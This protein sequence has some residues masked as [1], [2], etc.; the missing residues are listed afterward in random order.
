L[1]PR[2][3]WKL[4]ISDLDGSLTETS[5]GMEFSFLLKERG[6]LKEKVWCQMVKF[7]EESRPHRNSILGYNFYIKHLSV[8]FAKGIYGAKVETVEEIA[9]ELAPKIKLRDGCLETINKLK[10]W[11]YKIWI[12]SASPLPIVKALSKTLGVENFIGLEVYSKNGIYTD[13]CKRIMTTQQKRSLVN[14]FL[15][16]Y[17]F[18][19]G[20][21]D[22]WNDMIAY[23]GC[24]VK[25]LINSNHITNNN[26]NDPIKIKELSE[27]LR[28]LSVMEKSFFT[29]VPPFVV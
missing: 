18:S 20:L 5:S 21:G 27:I 10:S 23:Q 29:R 16:F 1:N 14:F 17:D 28:H 4:F 19:V 15:K 6:V 8:L 22:T 13:K 25:F 2:N 9:E 11:D 26:G 7:D 24:N 12:L 3:Y